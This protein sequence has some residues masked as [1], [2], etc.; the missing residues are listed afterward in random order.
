[1]LTPSLTR[2][3]ATSTIYKEQEEEKNRKYQHR[4][5]DYEMESFTPL[6]F[7]TN[8]GMGCRLQLRSQT[9]SR[10]ALRKE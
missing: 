6:V 3:K 8:G 5:L 9:P 10:E 2:K 4:L 1:M 7:R